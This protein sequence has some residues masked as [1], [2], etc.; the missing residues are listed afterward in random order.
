MSDLLLKT[1][2]GRFLI[3][4]QKVSCVKSFFC[5]QNTLQTTISPSQQSFR[6]GLLDPGGGWLVG[7]PTAFT[8]L[9]QPLS[10]SQQSFR[11]GLLDPRRGTVVGPPT[12][13]AI[14]CEP[15]SPLQQSFRAGLLDPQAGDGGGNINKQK[16]DATAI[17]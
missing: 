3:L 4:F 9:C 2:G 17:L 8:T 7:P 11:A 14:L 12:T 6:A 16:I 13:F 5:W 15:Q 1:A 10:P